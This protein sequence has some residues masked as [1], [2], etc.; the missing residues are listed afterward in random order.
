MYILL[1]ILNLLCSQGRVQE[2][3][4]R[5]RQLCSHVRSSVSRVQVHASLQT[6]QLQERS[7]LITLTTQCADIPKIFNS[8]ERRPLSP[9]QQLWP[10][11]QTRVRTEARA[12]R[13]GNVPP[14]SVPV[15][16]VTLESSAKLVNAV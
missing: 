14:S 9:D 7:L 16:M 3:E 10:A 4:L 11:G 12:G 15:L 5:P 1:I 8:T 6:P 13:V 2:R